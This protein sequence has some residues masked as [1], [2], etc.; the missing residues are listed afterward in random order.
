MKQLAVAFFA[1]AMCLLAQPAAAPKANTEQQDLERA[2]SAAGASSVEYLRAIESHL[3]KYPNTARRAELEAAAARA[4][5]DVRDNLATVEYGE[6]VLARRPDDLPLLE[7]VAR[8]LLAGGSKEACQGAVRYARRAEDLLV[9]QRNDAVRRG[10]AASA[11]AGD[12]I[13]REMAGVL[14]SEARSA[15]CLGRAQEA[16]A[17]ARHAY[18]TWPAADSARE[19]ARWQESLGHPLEAASALADAVTV[20]DPRVTL[21]ERVRDRDRMHQLYQQAKGSSAGEGDLMLE[22][23]DRNAALGH[24]RQSRAHADDP[25]AQLNDPMEFTITG[26]DGLK[27]SMAALKGKVIVLNFW[28]TWCVPCREEH[29]LLENA[30]KQFAANPDVVFLSIDTD[31]DRDAVK[32]FLEQQHW[33]DRVYFDDGLARKLSVMSL[34]TTVVFDRSAKVFSRMTG[35]SAPQFV[36]TLTERIQAALK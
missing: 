22:A 21:D 20:Q 14:L 17:L 19:A 13:D 31:D 27:L 36:N 9:Q 32:P 6:R 2:L 28:A 16:L 18:E 10:R 24:A 11:E 26:L 5:I 30:R 23:F 25:N 1:L 4:A 35:F 12:P 7:A 33:D 8:A 15:G 34:P 3:A 29:P